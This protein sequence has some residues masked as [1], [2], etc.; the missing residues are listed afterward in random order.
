M[1]FML[2]ILISE[3]AYGLWALDNLFH[4]ATGFQGDMEGGMKNRVVYWEIGKN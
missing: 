1:L 2:V 4:N 3:T